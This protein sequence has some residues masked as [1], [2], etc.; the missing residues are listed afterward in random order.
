MNRQQR[1]FLRTLDKS[2]NQARSLHAD[3]VKAMEI[4]GVQNEIACKQYLTELEIF[5]HAARRISIQIEVGENESSWDI[6]TR[7]AG[8]Q[9]RME[10]GL[11]N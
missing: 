9:S 2:I 1:T 7:A 8:Q 4:G 5:I 11:L 6:A 3:I 10:P